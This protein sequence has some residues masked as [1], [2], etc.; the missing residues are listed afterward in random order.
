MIKPVADRFILSQFV[1]FSLI[2]LSSVFCAIYLYNFY[3]LAIPL[4]LLFFYLSA[5]DTLLVYFIFIAS[6]PVSIAVDLPNG[7]STD[8]PGEP[9]MGGLMLIFFANLIF[10]KGY[11]SKDFLKHPLIFILFILLAWTVV[12]TIF[13]GK[14]YISFKHLLAKTWYVA[15]GVFL[16]ARLIQSMNDRKQFFWWMYVPL[17]AT[18]LI[19]LLRH[20]IKQFSFD[21]INDV[22]GPFYINHVMYAVMVSIF[23]PFLWFAASWYKKGS[24]N[25]QLLLLSRPLYLV[26]IW[27]SY[28]RS[29]W[30][31]IAGCLACYFIIQFKLLQWVFATL[32][33]GVLILIIYFSINDRYLDYAPNYKTTIYHGTLGAHL[34]ATYE[35]EDL[36]SAERVYRWIAGLQMWQDRPITGFGPATFYSFYKAYTVSSFE[37]YVSDNPEQ[38]TVHNYFLLVLDEQGV[39]GL[40]IFFVLSFMLFKY[41][42]RIYHET[43]NK[44][45]KSWVMAVLLCLVAIYINTFL[46]DLIETIKAGPLFFMSI[47]FLVNQDIRNKKQLKETATQETDVVAK[48]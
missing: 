34:T 10:K 33:T 15:V 11:V 29:S 8:F 6:I 21:S 2:L 18:I 35:M 48:G 12:T 7:F 30:A 13:S 1:V 40:L 17:T 39:P 44:N 4:A 47:A 32:M 9:I 26:A 16:T 27:F 20:A 19:I 28:T 14:L 31:A 43:K 45:E 46:N 25:R 36:S 37:T 38:S 24:F 5:T 42:Q 22:V 3:L 23:F 41:G